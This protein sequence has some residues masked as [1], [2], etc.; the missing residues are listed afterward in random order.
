MYISLT[1]KSSILSLSKI[2]SVQYWN[3]IS[4]LDIFRSTLIST[5][6]DVPPST[7]SMLFPFSE[8]SIP[9]YIRTSPLPPESTTPAS[10]NAFSNSGVL[11]SDSLAL[12]TTNSRNSIIS[13]SGLATFTAYSPLSLTTVRIVPSIGLITAL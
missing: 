5:L 8:D 7:D 13:I 12:F 10:F 9:S 2:N 11:F 3:F 6:D 4:S 1:A